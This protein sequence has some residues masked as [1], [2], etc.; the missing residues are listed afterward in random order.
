MFEKHVFLIIMVDLGFLF[1]ICDSQVI[2]CSMKIWLIQIK[3]SAAVLDPI[4][5]ITITIECRQEL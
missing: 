1:S 5:I 3:D 2:L 4:N